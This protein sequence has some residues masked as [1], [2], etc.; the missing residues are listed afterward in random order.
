M[1]PYKCDKCETQLEFIG[2]ICIRKWKYQCPK[3][4][5]IVIKRDLCQENMQYLMKKSKK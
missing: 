1:V 2:V 5:K 4:Y 3:C